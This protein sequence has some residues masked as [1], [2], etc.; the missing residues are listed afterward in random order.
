MP[1][2]NSAVQSLLVLHSFQDIVF[3]TGEECPPILF[4]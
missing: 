4:V 3:Y 2:A 1:I